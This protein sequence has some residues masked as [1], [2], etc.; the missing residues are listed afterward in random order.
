LVSGIDPNTGFV[1]TFYPDKT[2]P[3]QA[4]Q[5]MVNG[6]MTGVDI[7]VLRT[8][9]QGQPVLTNISGLILDKNNMPVKTL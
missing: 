3:Q 4:T 7:Y 5:V 1:P 2:N 8:Q 9:G 6:N